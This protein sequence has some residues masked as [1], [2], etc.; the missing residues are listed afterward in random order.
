MKRIKKK[1]L[2]CLFFYLLT[3]IVLYGFETNKNNFYSALSLTTLAPPLE[4]DFTF[5]STD[6]CSGNIITFQPKAN[7]GALPYTYVWNFG[8][9]GTATDRTPKHTFQAFGCG[10]EDYI[11]TLTVIDSNGEAVSLKKTIS[12]QQ[13]P[14]L[15][16]INLDEPGF[17]SSFERCGNNSNPNYTIRIGNQTQHTACIVSYHVDWGDGSSSSNVTFPTSHD[18][19]KLG[20]YTMVITAQGKNSCSTSLKYIVKNS[21]NPTGS[22]ITPGNTTNLCLPIAPI[23]FSIGSWGK[24]PSDTKYEIDFG[25]GTIK[26]YTQSQLENSIYYNSTNPETSQNFP[27]PHTYTQGN[28]PIGSTILLTISTSCGSTFL[29]A[30]PIII[31]D[32]PKV[33]FTLNSVLCAQTPIVISNTSTSGYG[34]NCSIVGVYTWDFGDG[35]TSN[36]VNPSHIYKKPGL[37]TIKLKAK[38]PCGASN[39]ITKTV[40]VEPL[41]QPKF[42][43]SQACSSANVKIT[44]T[45]DTSQGCAIASYNWE[46]T[47]Y[48]AGFCGTSALW[49]FTDGTTA[50]SRDPVFNFTNPGTYYVRL[51]VKNACGLSQAVTEAIK[52]KKLAEITMNP[53]K[54]YCSATTIYPKGTVAQSCGEA[55]EITYLWNFPGGIPASSTSLDPGPVYYPNAGHYEVS[56]HVTNSCGTATQTTDFL[57][58]DVI[59][60]VIQSKSLTI[61]SETNF[62]ISPVTNGIDHVPNGTTY[63]WSTPV[64]TPVGSLSG[65]TSQTT[66]T[67]TIKQKLIN[68]TFASA[69]ATYTVSP[70]SSDCPG[71]N[72]TITVL[73]FPQIKIVD[74]VTNSTCQG[75][76][77]GSIVLNVDGGTSST[78]GTTYSYSWKGPD[79]FTSSEKNLFNLKPGAYNLSISAVGKCP[80]TKTYNISEPTVFQFTGSMRMISCNGLN[81]GSISIKATG[82]TQ[83]YRYT[84][85]KNGAIYPATTSTITALQ[86]GFYEVTVTDANRCNTLAA[87]YT[88]EEPSVLKVELERQTN[89]LCH[90]SATGELT[91]RVN[92]GR[93][94]ETTPGVYTYNYLWSGPNGYVSTEQN[95]KNLPAGI[96]TLKVT[97]ASGCTD[98]LEVAI[99]QKQEIK[100]AYTKTDIKC[101]ATP[102]ASISI[103]NIS[104]GVPFQTGAP[105]I[106]KWSNLGTGLV[107]NNLSAGT[108]SITI[109][110]ALGCEKVFIIILEDAPVFTILPEV[111][112]ISCFGANDGSIRL[113]LKGGKA[114]VRLTWD[115]NST[116][117]TERNNLKAGKYSVTI[118]DAK[119]C[120]IHQ[121]FSIDEPQLL[122]INAV[123]SNSLDCLDPRTG[124]IH[125][126]VTGG[127][128]PFTYSW[129][130]GATTEDLT[131]LSAGTYTVVVTDASGCQKTAS[132]KIIRFDPLQATIK[133][134]TNANCDTKN[135]SQTL[136]AQVQGGVPPY[137]LSWSDGIVSGQNNEMVTSDKDGLLLL[138]VRDSYGCSFTLPHNIQLPNLGIAQF[139]VSSSAKDLYNWYSIYDPIH[140]TNLATGDY[141]KI[142][143]NFGDGSSS[144]DTNPDHIYKKEGN[145]VATQTVTYDADCQDIFTTNLAI[146]K[147]YFI[148]TPTAFTPNND[149]FNDRF[150]PLVKGLSKIAFE[151]YD[152]LGNLVYTETGDSL[153][154]WNGKVNGTVA[155]IGNY[156]FKVKAQTLYHFTITEEGGF[157]LLK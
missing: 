142:S 20:S 55:S 51:T 60:P 32:I 36:E 25:D 35:S 5:S 19:Q 115:D 10:F 17:V 88:L 28:C 54:N 138:L 108:Y 14:D 26:K 82:G 87:S 27:I 132:W 152:S 38:T 62:E 50:T 145:Y 126:M 69:T 80:F 104:G 52:V 79:G 117:G 13:K 101:N 34:N 67:T 155:E 21:T 22:F 86:P 148:V 16:F 68:T 71:E 42:T 156:Y 64:I 121:T 157:T 31:L 94:I 98:A 107:Q 3:T 111:K 1:Y 139:S 8:D 47:Q 135:V 11:V 72:F 9:G 140:F 92:G 85:T 129:S 78:N 58:G 39:E 114:P 61:C 119:S 102:N 83:P 30:G 65:F 106:V 24:N 48:I 149:S 59:T 141:K 33:G 15:K 89:I 75:L 96:Y 118:T 23:E 144:A 4:V 12:I 41:L 81:N 112:A 146:E 29:T 44:N 93:P 113:N 133:V 56:F 110:D 95:L 131:A 128:T 143:W 127:R 43:Y 136:T 57:V 91:I 100:I 97:D 40:C 125:L 109:L 74:K 46:V 120:D 134:Q 123:V 150:A 154:G 137:T 76:N 122:E 70:I 90:G 99:V 7:G 124:A 66:P 2:C 6:P 18:Y 45:T 73:V 53:I 147:G 84:W 105:Y 151:V 49:K 77:N 153:H 130:N 63:V 103:T 116:A 37:Y